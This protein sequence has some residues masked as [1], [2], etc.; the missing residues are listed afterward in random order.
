MTPKYLNDETHCKQ[1]SLRRSGGSALMKEDDLRVTIIVSAAR[2]LTCR[3]D[4]DSKWRLLLA[5][6]ELS[7][8]SLLSRISIEN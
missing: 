8:V 7:R 6:N 4:L 3:D 5:E 1:T 2:S